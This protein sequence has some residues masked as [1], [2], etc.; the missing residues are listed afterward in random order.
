VNET[1]RIP[2]LDGVRGCAIASVLFYHL[3]E[4]PLQ[5]SLG[6]G[7]YH[8]QALGR[9]TWSGV[10]LFF[11]LSGFLI[12]GILLD[13]RDSPN[14][15]RTFYARRFFRIVPLYVAVLCITLAAN[16]G[17][18]SEQIPTIAYFVFLQN[19]W[20]AWYGISG[21]LLSPTWS[22]A[23]E[24]QFY[25]TLPFIV[26]FVNRRYLVYVIS[27]GILLAPILRMLC[28]HL[29]HNFIAYYVLMPC[30]AD[31]LLLGVL[32]AMAMRDPRASRWLRSHGRTLSA[33]LF[34][35][36][37]GFV[38]LTKYSAAHRFL[39]IT[40]G[41]SWLALF[42]LCITLYAVTQP[43]SWLAAFLRLRALR[44]L[45]SI[46][47]GVYL[48]HFLIGSLIFREHYHSTLM[49][50]HSLGNLAAI[51]LSL[52]VTLLICQLSWVYFEKPMLQLGH[53]FRYGRKLE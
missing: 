31:T 51:V 6:S 13:T 38:L 8:L 35:F 24:E 25:L 46:A 34:I 30:R 12:G 17:K 33:I 41:H 23:V 50:L 7:W 49:Y 42:Y 10:D 11:V 28:Y 22:L 36:V 16:H 40:A 43:Q 15:F 29:T 45:G 5:P 9:L 39:L 44:W 2:E 14:Y 52:A 48:F 47:Y 20:M 3:I 27:A 53:R 32:G 37:I 4:A 18:F 21:Y 26:R 1:R 19:F